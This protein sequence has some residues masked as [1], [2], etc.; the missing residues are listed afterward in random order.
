MSGQSECAGLSDWTVTRDFKGCSVKRMIIVPLIASDEIKAVAQPVRTVAS[1]DQ[2]VI[3][4]TQ[5]R[6][7]GIAAD[8]DQ[9][10][11]LGR[12]GG[13]PGKHRCGKT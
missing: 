10:E 5:G 11:E 9:V 6:S 8:F 12:A 4:L 1:V 3:A 2:Q 13:Q 7:H